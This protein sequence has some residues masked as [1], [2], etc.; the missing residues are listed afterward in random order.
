MKILIVHKGKLPATY[1]GGTE[2]VVWY[3]GK[4]LVE[5]GHEVEYLTTSG[6]EI[7]FCKCR[8]IDENKPIEDQIGKAYDVVHFHHVQDNNEYGPVPAL[9]TIHGNAAP[10]EQLSLNAVFV[11]ADHARRHGAASFV[12]NGL[13]WEDYELPHLDLARK[14]FHFLGKAAWRVKNLRGAIQVIHKTR[15]EKL[16]VL[17]GHRV[18]FKMGMRITLSPRVRFFGM[19]GGKEKSALVNGSKG[20]IFPVR[21]HEPFGLSIIE[22]LFY[23][24]PVFGTPYGSLP[25]LVGNDFGFL[26]NDASVLADAIYHSEGYKPTICHE[27]ARDVFSANQMARAYMTLYEKVINGHTLNQSMPVSKAGHSSALLDWKSD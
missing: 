9:V 13:G 7:P 11:S 3:L 22:S 16:Y 19:V 2:R 18:N 23:G 15:D 14:Y 25:E 21:W 26:S 5:M 8:F 27:Y 4:A 6:S 12:Y 24:T 1:Y 17:G 20:L 10:G